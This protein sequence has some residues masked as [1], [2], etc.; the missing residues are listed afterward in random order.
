MSGISTPENRIYT[1]LKHFKKRT[2]QVLLRISSSYFVAF[3]YP[4]NSLTARG[5]T[6]GVPLYFPCNYSGS[7]PT[8]VEICLKQCML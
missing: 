8:L 4:E 3:S 1:G 7:R 2:H 5:T 6:K